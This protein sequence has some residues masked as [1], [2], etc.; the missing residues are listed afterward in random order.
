MDVV[1]QCLEF[2][3]MSVVGMAQAITVSSDFQDQSSQILEEF[4]MPANATKPVKIILDR[5][6]SLWEKCSPNFRVLKVHS[7]NTN[8]FSWVCF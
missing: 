4:A 5:Q 2:G 6:N 1:N 7:L 8:F 3:F